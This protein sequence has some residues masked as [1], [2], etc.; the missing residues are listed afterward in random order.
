M[1]NHSRSIRVRLAL[2]NAHTLL[3]PIIA[4]LLLAIATP[5]SLS[6]VGEAWL[7]RAA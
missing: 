6:I 7:V 2:L 3:L 5:I 4:L 1:R